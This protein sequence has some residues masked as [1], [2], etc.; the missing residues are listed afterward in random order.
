MCMCI[1]VRSIMAENNAKPGKTLANLNVNMGQLLTALGPLG[2]VVWQG[3]AWATEIEQNV[4][5]NQAQIE[6]LIEQVRANDEQDEANQ[7]AIVEAIEELGD[8]L[9]DESSGARD[10]PVD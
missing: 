10:E 8:R 2:L 1:G 4:K 7:A 5:A 3:L 6:I 9:S